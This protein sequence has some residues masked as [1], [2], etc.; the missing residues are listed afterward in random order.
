MKV[1]SITRYG[2]VEGEQSNGL[3]IFRGI[4]FAA[5]PVEPPS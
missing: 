2:K 5:S 1:I 4:P 3:A